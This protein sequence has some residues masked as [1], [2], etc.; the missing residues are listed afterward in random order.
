[1]Y[2]KSISDRCEA[3][4]QPRSRVGNCVLAGLQCRVKSEVNLGSSGYRLHIH[5]FISINQ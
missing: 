2:T 5:Y 3:G 4:N 1:M